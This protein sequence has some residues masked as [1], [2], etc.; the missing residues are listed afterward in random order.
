ML[1]KKNHGMTMNYFL[2]SAFYINLFIFLVAIVW[3]VTLL[4]IVSLIMSL[5]IFIIHKKHQ[6]FYSVSWGHDSGKSLSFYQYLRNLCAKKEFNFAMQNNPIISKPSIEFSP[7]PDSNKKEG[8]LH[9]TNSV[10]I[11]NTDLRIR[12]G[13]SQC[14]A[15]FNS[16]ILNLDIPDSALVNKEMIGGLHLASDESEF[17]F[18]IQDSKL[19]KWNQGNVMVKFPINNHHYFYNENELE[20]LLREMS[21]PLPVKGIE[22]VFDKSFD[23]CYS[24]SEMLNP[25]NNSYFNNFKD[26][27]DFI[28]ML[29]KS[30]NG[31][32]VGIRT[33]ISDKAEFIKFCKTM[34]ENGVFVDFITI[35]GEDPRR[36]TSIN[37]ERNEVLYGRMLLEDAVSFASTVIKQ[38]KLEHEVKLFAAGEINNGFELLKLV[39]L[40][41]NTCFAIKTQKEID[42]ISDNYFHDDPEVVV[43]NNLMYTHKKVLREA[44]Q[45]MED[46]GFST[47]EQVDPKMFFRRFNRTTIKNFKEIYFKNDYTNMFE[48]FIHLN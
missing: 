21:M 18:A 27:C 36:L 43:K 12:I 47:I 45:I 25:V 5:V 2:W 31:K 35:I 30:A 9:S 15:A 34:N 1:D 24:L 22:I 32:L 10:S 3:N 20:D 29:R 4:I 23:L 11:A 7:N 38:Y 39:A 6:Q 16:S 28:V 19:D 13:G 26:L 48:E 14:K 44:I 17:A 33:G 37:I 40:G 8:V 46:A 42:Q 41:A